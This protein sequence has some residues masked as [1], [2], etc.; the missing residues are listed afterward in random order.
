MSVVGCAAQH[1][2][3][4]AVRSEGVGSG[5]DAAARR[6]VHGDAVLRGR[7]DDGLSAAGRDSD[8]SQ[9][10]ASAAAADGSG[11]ALSEASAECAGRSGASDLP[12]FAAGSAD[13]ASQPGVVGGHHVHPPVAGVRVPGGDPGLVQPLRAVVVAVDHP[14]RVVLRPGPAGGVADRH[15]GDLQHGPGQPVHQRRLD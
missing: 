6:A 8:R 3:L 11:G 4:R 15:A 5:G 2:V 9:S 14:G 7:A 12:V 1:G 13:R 10:G